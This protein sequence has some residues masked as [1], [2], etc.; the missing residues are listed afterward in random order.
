MFM[1]L[2]QYD[3]RP[4]GKLDSGINIGFILLRAPDL[5]SKITQITPAAIVGQSSFASARE[6]NAF[7]FRY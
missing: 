4:D 7:L 5:N 2:S 1:V 6:G 3:V